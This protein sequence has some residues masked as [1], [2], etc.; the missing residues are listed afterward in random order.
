MNTPMVVT[1]QRGAFFGYGILDI[2]AQHV[3][4]DNARMIVYWSAD[5]RSVVGLAANGPSKGCRIGPRAPATN[6]LIRSTSPPWPARISQT[7]CWQY[8]N[9]Q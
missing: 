9:Q 7:V 1:T 4:L 2:N 5:C 6:Q 8:G 3:R